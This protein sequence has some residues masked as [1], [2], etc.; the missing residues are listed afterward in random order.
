MPS[1]STSNHGLV[2]AGGSPGAPARRPRRPRRRRRSRRP[3]PASRAP[4]SAVE[5]QVP[6]QVLPG[7]AGVAFRVVRGHEAV[8]APPEGRPGTSRPG[9]GP[10]ERPAPRGPSGDGAAGQH[11]GRRQLRTPGPRRAARAPGPRPR[12]PRPPGRGRRCTVGSVTDP[13][14]FLARLGRR[15]R[16]GASCCSLRTVARRRR[17]GRGGAAP[18]R[19]ARGCRGGAAPSGGPAARARSA[20]PRA[21]RRARSGCRRP[22]S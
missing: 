22:G 9:P 6:E 12:W 7:L 21:R 20:W 16:L 10:G 19:A 3:R 14:R 2:I 5:R 1:M 15:R 13:R 8:V 11:D 17:P 4:A 18:R